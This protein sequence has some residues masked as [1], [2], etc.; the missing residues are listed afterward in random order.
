MV[1]DSCVSSINE[2]RGA[3]LA[4]NNLIKEREGERERERERERVRERE[5]ERETFTCN[6]LPCIL[7]THL[8]DNTL[9][10]TSL[11]KH[12]TNQSAAIATRVCGA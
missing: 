12:M 6:S 5:R 4:E 9:L 1:E 7:P 10:K 11:P 3:S 8:W 2:C